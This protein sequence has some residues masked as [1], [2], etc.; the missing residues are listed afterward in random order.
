MRALID[1]RLD[2]AE[3]ASNRIVELTDDTDDPA[4]GT[5]LRRI[6]VIAEAAVDPEA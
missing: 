4:N 3:A 2:D 1:G 6:S 5:E